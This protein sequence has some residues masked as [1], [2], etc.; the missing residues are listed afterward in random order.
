MAARKHYLVATALA[1]VLALGAL[2]GLAGAAWFEFGSNEKFITKV[3]SEG[4]LDLWWVPITN[5]SGGMSD[6]LVG[7]SVGIFPFHLADYTNAYDNYD[8][9]A[10][11]IYGLPNGPVATGDLYTGFDWDIGNE[12]STYT[13]PNFF[14]TG[15]TSD[16][17]GPSVNS[18]PS[19]WE[20]GGGFHLT[21]VNY[22]NDRRVDVMGYVGDIFANP[23]STSAVAAEI[24]AAGQLNLAFSL[25]GVE[26]LGTG[27]IVWTLNDST[28]STWAGISGTGDGG[29]GGET[30]EPATM[31][32]LASALGVGAWVRRRRQAKAKAV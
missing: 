26:D 30:P 32:L 13:G 17:Q 25:V 23:G 11:D 5:T 29:G 6:P 1:V 28:A 3:Q 20:I 21:S 22:V 4:K 7:M 14:I 2:P 27:E 12:Y 18:I 9:A 10:G 19:Y 16:K 24:L 15:D 31:T 8:L